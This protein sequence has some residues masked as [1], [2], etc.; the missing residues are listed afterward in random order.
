MNELNHLVRAHAR[1]CPQ[2]FIHPV[3]YSG[4]AAV[5]HLWATENGKDFPGR[6]SIVLIGDPKRLADTGGRGS[7]AADLGWVPALGGANR[8]YGGLPALQVCNGGDHI[9][10][11]EVGW[12][13]YLHGVH[14]DYDFNVNSYPNN[15]EGEIYQD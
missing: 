12:D 7:A 6:A 3:G 10:N 4:G 14:A 11:S 13:G 1:A 15:A 8:D 9:C 5:V 2:D